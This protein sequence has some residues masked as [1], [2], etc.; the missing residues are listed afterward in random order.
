LLFGW[1][2]HRCAGAHM[3]ELIL[4]EMAKPLFAKGIARAP[5]PA[6]QLSKG[7]PS[8]IP[9]GQFARRLVV[10]FD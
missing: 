3:A 10:Q 6:G 5:G 8:L 9:D 4:L 7:D 1:A 2:Q